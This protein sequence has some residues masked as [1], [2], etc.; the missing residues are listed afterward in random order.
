MVTLSGFA[1]SHQA[2][3]HSALSEP[4]VRE[5]LTP[6]PGRQE[7]DYIPVSSNST[8]SPGSISLIIPA[9]NEVNY[10]EKTLASVFKAKFR[11]QGRLEVIV[12]DN[13]S[14][15]ATGDIARRHGATV[16][17]EPINQIARARNTGATMASGDYLIFVDADTTSHGDI[18]EKVNKLLSG[19]S[20]IGGGAW[21]EPDSGWFSRLMFR[22]MVNYPLALINVTVGPFLFCE[23]IAFEKVGGFDE[24][25]YAAEEFSLA[26]R[27]KKEGRKSHKQWKIIRYHTGHIITTSSRKFSKFGGLE[28]VVQNANL[29]WNPN[30]R[31]RQ[32]DH[33][34]F[35]YESRKDGQQK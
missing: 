8:S 35:W 5:T 15:D 30:K 21:V 29:L 16:V 19:G 17:F 31:L 4:R 11:Y 34:A 32:K 22:F 25:L 18:L 9:F 28:M 26:G 7:D 14:T 13:N 33:C 12:V 20:V 24:S 27:L 6:P 2:T 10:I 23:R 3:R 1:S